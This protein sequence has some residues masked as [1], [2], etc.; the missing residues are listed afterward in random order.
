MQS[1]NKLCVLFPLLDP[2]EA[3]TA[4]GCLIGRLHSCF[5]G[6]RIEAKIRLPGSPA[7]N[8]LWPA[9]WVCFNLFL[10]HFM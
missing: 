2:L 10:L 8:G 6:G 9:F 7:V 5:Q 3:L 4:G 1:W